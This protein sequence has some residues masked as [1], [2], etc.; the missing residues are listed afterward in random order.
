MTKLVSGHS[1][2]NGQVSTIFME[3]ISAR[4]SHH[5]LAT[6]AFKGGDLPFKFVGF[7]NIIG[8]KERY[9]PPSRSGNST[10][11]R[12]CRAA[13]LSMLDMRYAIELRLRNEIGAPVGGSVVY[14]NNFPIR[15]GLGEHAVDSARQRPFAVKNRNDNTYFRGIRQLSSLLMLPNLVKPILNHGF[16]L[17]HPKIR[18]PANIKKTSSQARVCR[19]RVFEPPG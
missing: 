5:I 11:T 1:H 3:G 8:I 9:P 19:L 17:Y 6:M 15:Q 10:I 13:V 14:K 7:P 4:A 16:Q 2:A 12:R 18:S